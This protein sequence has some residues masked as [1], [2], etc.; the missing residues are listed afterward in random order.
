M[1]KVYNPHPRLVNVALGNGK[2]VRVM[3][4][5]TATV[6]QKLVERLL[7]A[8]ELTTNIPDTLEGADGDDDDDGEK[9]AAKKRKVTPVK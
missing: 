7:K 5:G 3:P 1:I 8:K 2:F 4:L 6:E 9:P